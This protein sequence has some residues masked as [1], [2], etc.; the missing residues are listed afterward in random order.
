MKYDMR[1]YLLFHSTGYR[2]FSGRFLHLVCH[3]PPGINYSCRVVLPQKRVARHY[4]SFEGREGLR[5]KETLEGLPVGGL[6]G[7]EVL[8]PVHAFHDTLGA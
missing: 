4:S 7:A 6:A 1:G 8:D 5:A 2:F 3:I